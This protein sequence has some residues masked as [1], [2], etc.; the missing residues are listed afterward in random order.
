VALGPGT[1]HQRRTIAALGEAK[2]R[3]LDVGDLDRLERLR[4]M[5]QGAEQ[6]HLVLV[7]AAGFT[8]SVVDFAT[9]RVDVHLVDLEDVY[10]Q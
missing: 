8:P 1:G 9:N 10:C 2:L 3:E 7:S 4:P 6:A 5:L